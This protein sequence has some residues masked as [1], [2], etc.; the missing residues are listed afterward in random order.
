MAGIDHNFHIVR[1][2]AKT[3]KGNQ[4]Y[5][6]KYCK[7]T[8]N[9]HAQKVKVKKNYP[10]LPFLMAKV[11]QQHLGDEESSSR[12]IERLPSD[13]KNIAPTIG[14]AKSHHQLKS[15]CRKKE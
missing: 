14:G 10:Y 15:L 8:K 6:R 3:L 13:P 4:I 11:L 12:R 7:R 1:P 5:M 9:W 2:C